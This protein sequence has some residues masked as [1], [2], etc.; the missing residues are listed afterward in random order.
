MTRSKETKALVSAPPKKE[1]STPLNDKTSPSPTNH[2]S[3]RSPA[4]IIALLIALIAITASFYSM[5][6]TQQTTQRLNLLR[7]EVSLLKEHQMDAKTLFDNTLTTT[8]ES[9]DT[10]K[11]E[12]NSVKKQLQVTLQQSRY[13][14]KDW[15]LLKARYCLELAQINAHWSDNSDTTI[16]LLQQANLLLAPLE[17]QHSF[18]VRQAITKEIIQLQ[19]IATLDIAGL[20]SQLD[21]IDDLLIKLPLKPVVVPVSPNTTTTTH[22]KTSTWGE[23]LQS[24]MDVLQRLIVIRRHDETIQPMA[25]PAYESMLRESLHLN[26]QQAQWAI[27][28]HN[29]TLYQRSLT[30][31]RQQINQAFEPNTAAT[32]LVSHQLQSLQQI[33][34]TQQKPILDESLR[35]LNQLIETKDAPISNA[36]GENL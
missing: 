2:P 21:A 28:Q 8:K 15:V 3:E 4:P 25:S 1:Q 16:A 26:L 22:T 7:T 35:L 31:A 10:L 11:N 12:L 20:L 13:L 29:E 27:L 14:S 6:T 30:Q 17:D 34:L 18:N 24:S 9:E 32:N 33:H 5:H 19:S 36:E 23:Y